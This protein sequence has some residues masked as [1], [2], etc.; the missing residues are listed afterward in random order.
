[1]ETSP[2]VDPYRDLELMLRIER[3]HRFVEA[4]MPMTASGSRA[5]PPRADEPVDTNDNC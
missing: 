5:A 4:D 1:M 2:P 3:S